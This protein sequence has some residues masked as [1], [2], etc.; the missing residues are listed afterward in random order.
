MLERLKEYL[1]PKIPDGHRKIVCWVCH[2]PTIQKYEKLYDEERE[3]NFEQYSCTTCGFK[4]KYYER[5]IEL[6]V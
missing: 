6:G 2:R 5:R 4:S 3:E 1:R